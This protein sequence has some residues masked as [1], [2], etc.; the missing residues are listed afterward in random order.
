MSGFAWLPGSFDAPFC[1]LIISNEAK[2]RA[3]Y[4]CSQGPC[5]FLPTL[6]M[7]FWWISASEKTFLSQLLSHFCKFVFLPF[8]VFTPLSLFFRPDQLL[9]DCLFPFSRLFPNIVICIHFRRLNSTLATPLPPPPPWWF[10]QNFSS[11][12]QLLFINQIRVLKS[13][14]KTLF[15]FLSFSSKSDWL[16]DWSSVDKSLLSILYIINFSLALIIVV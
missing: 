16:S 10:K 8:S 2:P 5:G 9:F 12:T 4:E 1:T 11:K 13:K 15:A 6:W 3:S 7:S 14:I